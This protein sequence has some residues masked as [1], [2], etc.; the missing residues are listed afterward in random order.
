MLGPLPD[1]GLVSLRGLGCEWPIW[2]RRLRRR[3]GQ[4]PLLGTWR[5]GYSV[6]A[7]GRVI[8][9]DTADG[10]AV[11]YALVLG[12]ALLA[13]WLLWSGHFDNPFLLALGVASSMATLGLALRMRIVD[14]EGVPIALGIR[15]FTRYVP[16]LLKEIVRANWQVA[17]IILSP[18]MPLRRNVIQVTAD[19][20]TAF[21][22][23][24][25]ANSITLTPG[26][27]SI[28][29]EDKQIAVHSLSFVGNE[30]ELSGEMERRICKLE[31]K[32]R[33]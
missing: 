23:V 22:R 18:R 8:R 33:A 3:E 7:V 10:L 14:E 17:K 5:R 13:N 12:I 21:G 15:L 25:L 20:R 29:M 6:A 16:W 11:I 2:K 32:P 1:K 19:P 9:L 26:T 27:V 30:E 31:G 4:F 24:I 28:S